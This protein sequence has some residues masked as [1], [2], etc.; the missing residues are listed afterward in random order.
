MRD[1]P[2]FAGTRVH[3]RGQ[4]FILRGVRKRQATS[5]AL[6]YEVDQGRVAY[7]RK[8]DLMTQRVVLPFGHAT[9]VD[10]YERSGA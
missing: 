1:S 7:E 6:P 5:I 10:L 4:P 8:P 2:H 3:Y 9:L